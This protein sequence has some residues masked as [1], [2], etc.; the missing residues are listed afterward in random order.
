M[1]VQVNGRVKSTLETPALGY[2]SVAI[3]IGVVN[4]LSTYRQTLPAFVHSRT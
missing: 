3:A 4:V 2:V 1:A